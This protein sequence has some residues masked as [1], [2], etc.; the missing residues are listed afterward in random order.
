MIIRIALFKNQNTEKNG[1]F[2]VKELLFEELKSI[3][4]SN[5]N[6]KDK[7]IKTVAHYRN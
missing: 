2:I 3:F 5:I 4:G 7:L 6:A 1:N